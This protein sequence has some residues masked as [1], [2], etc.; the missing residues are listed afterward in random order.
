MRRDFMQCDTRGSPSRVLLFSVENVP[1]SS[2]K[3]LAGPGVAVGWD[4]LILNDV[5]AADLIDSMKVVGVGMSVEDGVN[6]GNSGSDGLKAKVGGGV[7]Q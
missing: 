5:E 3:L 1:K 4:D 6:A 2:A 7:D